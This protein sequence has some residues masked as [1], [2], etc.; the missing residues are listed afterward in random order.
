M[1][2]GDVLIMHPSESHYI[3]LDCTMAYERFVANFG[4]DLL[5]S[6][7]PSGWLL[8]PFRDRPAGKFNLYKSEE[9]PGG[10][11]SLLT[12]ALL[13]AMTPTVFFAIQRLF[14]W[15]DKIY[16]RIRKWLAGRRK[17]K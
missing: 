4:E 14:D 5:L 16:L 15:G 3:D 9:F 6:L 7:D 1:E 2:P 8:A 10:S 13:L 12:M 11:E 17:H